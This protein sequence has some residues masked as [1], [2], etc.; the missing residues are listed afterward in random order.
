MVGGTRR[1]TCMIYLLAH[2][3]WGWICSYT[4]PALTT[5]GEELVIDGPDHVYLSDVCKV[6][7]V[8]RVTHAL[9][10]GRSRHILLLGV[11]WFSSVLLRSRRGSCPPAFTLGSGRNCSP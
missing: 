3:S 8:A 2:F 6:V 1:T 5:A 9:P 10:C 4:D 11:G 7:P